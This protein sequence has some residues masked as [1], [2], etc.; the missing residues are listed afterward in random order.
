VAGGA[1]G[2]EPL[3]AR[4]VVGYRWSGRAQLALAILLAVT[5]E[6][7]ADRCYQQFTS[8]RSWLRSRR[9]ARNTR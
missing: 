1:G 5:D 9:T 4:T 2:G 7:T 6:P 3:A 8:G